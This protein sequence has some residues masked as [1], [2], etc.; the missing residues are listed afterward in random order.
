MIQVLLDH[1]ACRLRCCHSD[2]NASKNDVNY[3]LRGKRNANI[4]RFGG[5]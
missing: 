3:G 2:S 5:R 1:D 4:S